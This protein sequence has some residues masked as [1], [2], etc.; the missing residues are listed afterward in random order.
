MKVVNILTTSLLIM[1]MFGCMI[2][3][4][5][6]KPAEAGIATNVETSITPETTDVVDVSPG[7]PGQIAFMGTIV[8]TNYNDVT[9]LIAQLNVQT[10][11]GVA[12]IDKTQFVFQSSRQ[13]DV[14]HVLVQVPIISTVRQPAQ[15]A[16]SGSWQQAA[17]GS[18]SVGGSQA[19]FLVGQFQMMTVW[20]EM[21]VIETGP[22]TQ[23]VF[24]LRLENTGNYRDEFRIEVTNREDL[25][26]K[27]Y[28]IP[29]LP[30]TWVELGEPKTFTLPVTLPHDWVL[31]VDKPETIWIRVVST[32]NELIK[33]DYPLIIRVRGIYIP[34]FEPILLIM[35][36]GCIAAVL[37]RKHDQ[38]GKMPLVRCLYN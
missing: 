3:L 15:I 18:G 14:F 37:K 23:A 19:A 29:N 38:R 31:W 6:P 8:V 22:G 32:S 27:G 16:V 2:A 26:E 35:S 1:L 20:S 13:D 24:S 10:N 7:S 9:P 12:T 36:F 17:G 33:E 11:V 30:K 21:P 4:V 34:G 5:I 25:E 28:I